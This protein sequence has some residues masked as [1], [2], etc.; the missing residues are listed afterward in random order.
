MTEASAIVESRAFLDHKQLPA[1]LIVLG[2]GFIG[3]ELACL[4]AVLGVK[5]ILIE[6]LE[7]ILLLLDPD[8]RREVRTHMETTLGIRIL[9]GKAAQAVSADSRAIRCEEGAETLAAELL[10]CG[11]GRKPVTD[12]LKLDN[13][14]LKTGER[15]FIEADSY[16]RTSAANIFAVGDVAGK[17]QLAHFATA[18]GITAAENA[19]LRL[20][21]KHET[22]VPNV[23]SRRPKSVRSASRRRRPGNKIGL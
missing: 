22:V 1:T 4:A 20:Q 2:G 5:V 11:V 13:A 23:F 16:C 19:H 10:L 7:D 17:T 9:T 6:L 8:V 3:C 21:R 18:Q 12:G 14:G 15:G